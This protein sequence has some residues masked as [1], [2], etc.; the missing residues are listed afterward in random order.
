M[1]VAE[2]PG[3]PNLSRKTHRLSYGKIKACHKPVCVCVWVAGMSTPVVRAVELLNHFFK[4][5]PRPKI[6]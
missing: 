2:T 3:T 4:Y 5:H 6:K 1:V